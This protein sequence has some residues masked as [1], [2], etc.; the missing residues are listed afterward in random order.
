MIGLIKL[1]SVSNQP[2]YVNPMGIVLITPSTPAFCQAICGN[3]DAC[4]KGST[5]VLINHLPMQFKDTPKE[6][7]SALISLRD[8][9]QD[10]AIKFL[11]KRNREDWQDDDE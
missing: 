9:Q 11:K 3:P 7:I 10:Q 5:T 6:I 1:T 2:F 4:I 8:S